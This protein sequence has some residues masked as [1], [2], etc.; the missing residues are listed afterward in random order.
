MKHDERNCPPG[1]SPGA[2]KSQLELKL[3]IA[4]N[5]FA[6]ILTPQQRATM[7]QRDAV[8]RY[9]KRVRKSP[10]IMRGFT[11]AARSAAP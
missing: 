3:V 10:D 9:Q 6:D 11:G 4:E 7:R 2:A 8:H 5:P 1:S